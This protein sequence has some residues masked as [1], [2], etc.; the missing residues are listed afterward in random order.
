MFFESLYE[1]ESKLELMLCDI[2]KCY[3]LLAILNNDTGP[4]SD[5]YYYPLSSDTC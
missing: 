1:Y 3:D 5:E 2:N 4:S